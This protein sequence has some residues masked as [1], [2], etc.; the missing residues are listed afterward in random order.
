MK[1]FVCDPL[2]SGPLVFINK[3]QNEDQL[4]GLLH[5]ERQQ[6]VEQWLGLPSPAD[7]PPKERKHN[8][9]KHHNFEI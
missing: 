6:N 1:S 8:L 7:H 9:N 2:L 4:T 3:S 5:E